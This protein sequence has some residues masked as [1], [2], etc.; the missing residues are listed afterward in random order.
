MPLYAYRCS[1]CGHDCEFLQSFSDPPHRQCPNC[2][3]EQLVKQITAP[4]FTFKGSG[5]YKDLYGSGKAES[6]KPAAE[7]TAQKSDSAAAPSSATTT[8]GEKPASTATK[9]ET[10][11]S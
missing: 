4:A 9:P 2:Q 8:S 11:S 7:T 6:A 3:Q 1:N 10:P 5:W